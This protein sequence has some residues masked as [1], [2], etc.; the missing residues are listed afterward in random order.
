MVQ[1]I[2]EVC[3]FMSV[4]NSS[5]ISVVLGLEDNFECTNIVHSVRY[6]Y[7]GKASKLLLG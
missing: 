1:N 4:I 7:S 6:K 2:T 5:Q 3:T